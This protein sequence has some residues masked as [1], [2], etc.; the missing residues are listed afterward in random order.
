MF[1]W[2][3]LVLILV[4]AVVAVLF[5][6][7]NQDGVTVRLPGGL[8]YSHVPLF[9]LAFVPL[10]VGFVLGAVSGW[11]GGLKYRQRADRLKRQIRTLE[12]ELSNLRNQPLDN[13]LQL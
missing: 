11:A 6:I 3:N 8:L 9:V 7:A 13:D 5:A 4:L 1:G 2:L 12:E 10:F